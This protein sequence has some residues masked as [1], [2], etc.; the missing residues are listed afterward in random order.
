M[1]LFGQPRKTND[2]G[3]TMNRQKRSNRHGCTLTLGVLIAWVAGAAQAGVTVTSGQFCFAGNWPT[4]QPVAAGSAVPASPTN[5]AAAAVGA[6]PFAIGEYGSPHTVAHLNDGLYG[7]AYSWITGSSGKLYRS[8]ALGGDYGSLNMSFAG[9]A[10][11]NATLY[12]LSDIVF[13]RSAANEYSDRISG[14]V[15]VQATTSTDLSVI[16]NRDASTDAQWTTLGYITT[17]DA[18]EHLFTFTNPVSATGIR[19]VT[20]AGNCIDEIVVHGTSASSPWGGTGGFIWTNATGGAWSIS[21]NWTNGTPPN[22]SYSAVYMTQAPLSD[23]TITNDTTYGI[24]YGQGFQFGTL[25]VDATLGDGSPVIFAGD[26]LYLWLSDI[27]VQGHVILSNAV[28]SFSEIRTKKDGTTTFT[29][30]APTRVTQ[31]KLHAYSGTLSVEGTVGSA[32]LPAGAWMHLDAS[33]TNTMALA[34]AGDGTCYVQQWNDADGNGRYAYA[35]AA[36]NRPLWNVENGI[37]NVSFGVLVF[38]NNGTVMNGKTLTWSEPDTGIRTA[39]L[40]YSDVPESQ[41]T[42]SLLC[43]KNITTAVTFCRNGKKLFSASA[44]SPAVVN[45]IQTVDSRR[46]LGTSEGISNGFYVV[47]VTTTNNASADCFARDH[48]MHA[49]G[50]KLAEVVLYNRE[51]SR[52]ERQTA[53]AYLMQKWFANPPP[54]D[55]SAG[56]GQSASLT[57]ESGSAFHA[58]S[59]FRTQNLTINGNASKTGSGRLTAGR[60][61]QSSGTFALGNGTLAVTGDMLSETQYVATVPAPAFHLDAC[62]Y[63]NSMVVA[64]D[65]EGT[66]RV[67]RWADVSTNGFVASAPDTCIPPMLVTN[68]LNGRPFVDFGNLALSSVTNSHL[69]WNT[70]NMSIRTVVMVYSDSTNYYYYPDGRDLRSCF[71]GYI[72]GGNDFWR[73]NEGTLAHSS[74]AGP[75]KYGHMAVDGN[76]AFADTYLPAGFHVL[77]FV[78]ASATRSDAFARGLNMWTGG[79]RLAEVLV[80]NEPLPSSLLRAAEQRLMVKWLG[81]NRPGYPARAVAGPAGAPW[82]H[83]DASDT[84]SMTLASESGT[85]YVR[86]WNDVRTNGLFAAASADK[87]RPVWRAN[88]GFPYVDFGVLA[89]PQTSADYGPHLLWSETN[90]SIRAVFLVYSD[91]DSG[92]AQHILGNLTNT[93]PYYRGTKPLLLDAVSANAYVVSGTHSLNYGIVNGTATPL[94]GGF[95]VIGIANYHSRTVGGN[96]FAR[97]Q[98]KHAGGQKLA[99][100]LIYNRELTDYEFRQTRRYLMR[101]WFGAASDEESDLYR[102]SCAD[103]AALDIGAGQTLTCQTNDCPGTLEKRGAGRLILASGSANALSVTDGEL[104]LARSFA[105]ASGGTLSSLNLGTNAT[106]NLCGNGLVTTNLNGSGTVSNGTVTAAAIIPGTDGGVPQTLRV[107]GNLVLSSGVEIKIDASATAADLVAVNGALTLSGTGHVSVRFAQETKLSNSYPLITFGSIVNA[108]NLSNW[109]VDM[110]PSGIYTASLVREG[111]AI[112]LVFHSRGTLVLVQ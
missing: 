47:A 91:A 102:L 62:D 23:K 59:D 74:A 101:K 89:G 83:V 4:N 71:L 99:E 25:N 31:S 32:A 69:L 38:G 92:S 75:M 33:L 43:T 78:T 42:Q 96:V 63:T 110:S 53:E 27:S 34:D 80:W 13:G 3:T 107:F 22:S 45:G 1:A 82:L 70:T 106:V 72:S 103:G 21:A 18:Y 51:L 68:G 41:Y 24:A 35:E 112:M 56:A 104:W 81:R 66:L 54:T 86:Q 73:G 29:E 8:V 12:T 6:I 37:A 108:G 57:L 95:H 77:S 30:W 36:V 15:Y 2:K 14:N 26:A 40:V 17:T 97:D 88:N 85:L 39:F 60:I 61:T 65:G 98:N 84:N 28:E 105:T 109:S 90:N 111:N 10:F 48:L 20:T 44:A 55:A 93:P 19:I 79:Q 46:I 67:T 16:T 52:S 9:V 50:Q 64:P 11:S 76:P 94:P 58:S 5:I 87:Y 100:V 7:N 49:G